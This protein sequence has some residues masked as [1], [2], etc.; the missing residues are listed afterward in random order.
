[1]V[2]CE[3]V[4]AYFEINGFLARKNPSPPLG[5]GRKNIDPLPEFT[6]YNPKTDQ[7]SDKLGFRLFSGD[8]MQVHSAQIFVLG[9]ENTSFSNSLLSSEPRLVKFLRQEVDASRMGLSEQEP[10]NPQNHPFSNSLLSS[11][12][13]LVKFLR[14][15]VDASRMGLSEQ[16]PDNRQNHP[17]RVIVV[18][19]LPARPDRMNVVEQ[20]FRKQGVRGVLTLKS[21]LENLFR[22]TLPSKLQLGGGHILHLLQMLKSYDLF[23]DPQVD[24][25]LDNQI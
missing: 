18:P 15:E 22:Q 12:P 8:L 23:R 24:M 19:A 13:R 20:H 10:D 1:M 5:I 7:N 11:E 3:V 2:E 14:Q 4:E 6:V 21:I 25:F 9:W 17:L 16:E